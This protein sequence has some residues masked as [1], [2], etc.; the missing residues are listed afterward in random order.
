MRK[1]PRVSEV[2]KVHK[3]MMWENWREK[4]Q[5][6][7]F[8]LFFTTL[9]T[10]KIHKSCTPDILKKHDK[11]N[12]KNHSKW[13]EEKAGNN[14]AQLEVVSSQIDKR[15]C[16]FFLFHWSILI[17][18]RVLKT[19]LLYLSRLWVTY[20]LFNNWFPDNLTVR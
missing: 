4:V 8:H 1:L 13:E 20:T 12:F 18:V 11:Y 15:T 14:C 10:R 19:F 2:W 9:I 16:G 6:C 7:I 5:T 17:K 3:G